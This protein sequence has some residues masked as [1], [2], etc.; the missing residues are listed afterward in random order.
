MDIYIHLLAVIPSLVLGAINLSLEKGTLTHKRI[1]KAWAVLMLI[2]AISSLFITPT[3][4]LTWLHL[5]S[6][7]VIVCIPVGVISIRKGNIKRHTHCMTGAYIG[8][9]ISAYFAVVTPSRFLYGVFY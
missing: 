8:T 3:G 1:G 4:S 6:I 9:V 7:L 2:T 5:F